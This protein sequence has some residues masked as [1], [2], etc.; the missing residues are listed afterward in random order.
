VSG[1]RVEFSEASPVGP[2]SRALWDEYMALVRD[3]LGP[4]FEPTEQIFAGDDAFAAPGAAWVVLYDDGRPVACGGLRPLGPGVVEIKRMFVTAASRGRG[5]G[6]AL[7]RELER[8]AA[9]GGAKRVRLLTT[10]V[11]REARAL[12]EAEGYAVVETMIENG[13]HDYWL[14][15]ELGQDSP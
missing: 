3:R 12:Y 11:L 6:R 4:A 8:R 5:H 10:E 14:E 7:L 9:A 2:A 1:P 13:R 15:K